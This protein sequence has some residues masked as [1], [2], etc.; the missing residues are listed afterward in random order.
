MSHLCP[1]EMP[2]Y[3]FKA[4]ALEADD[5]GVGADERARRTAH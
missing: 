1:I 5:Y 3:P 2:D 4:M